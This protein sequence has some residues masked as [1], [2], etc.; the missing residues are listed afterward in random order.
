ML[1]I[2]SR[3]LGLFAAA[4]LMSA[5]DSAE[6]ARA[7][8]PYGAA[9]YKPPRASARAQIYVLNNTDY[10]PG[11][12][13]YHVSISLWPD[14]CASKSEM[15]PV[16]SDIRGTSV[17]STL[18]RRQFAE[19]NAVLQSAM[20]K[21]DRPGKYRFVRG[22][23]PEHARLGPAGAHQFIHAVEGIIAKGTKVRTETQT[24]PR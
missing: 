23:D 10:A 20:G 22:T 4:S 21:Q 5:C 7:W 15:A 8:L 11:D 12:E 16:G 1:Y 9:G 18:S 3:L 2:T 19:L 24:V 6:R 17:T 13:Y 14:R